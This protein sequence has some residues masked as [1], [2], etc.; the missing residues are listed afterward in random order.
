MVVVS[1]AGPSWTLLVLSV[2]MY[3][4]IITDISV[5]VAVAESES[6]ALLVEWFSQ[7]AW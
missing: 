5:G 4:T 7:S 2:H 6:G 3:Q 1:V